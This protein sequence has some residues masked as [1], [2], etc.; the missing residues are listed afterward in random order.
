MASGYPPELIGFIGNCEGG[1]TVAML[2]NKEV[3]EPVPLFKFMT[4]LLK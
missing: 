2:G 1:L 3:V 4:T